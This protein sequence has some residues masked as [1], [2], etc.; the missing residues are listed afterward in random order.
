MADNSRRT[1]FIVV[2]IVSAVLVASI[3]YLLYRPIANVPQPA[4][5]QGAIRAGSPEFERYR[6]K[7]VLDSIEA[8]ES[9]RA[10]GDIVMTLQGTVR[11]FTGRTINGLEVYGAVVDLNGKPV[12]EKT[13]A[14]IPN[15]KAEL[16][17]NETMQARVLLEGISKEAVR[18]NIKM[19][20]VAVR[21]KN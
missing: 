8:F 19:E 14:V 11:N 16:A 21:F 15:Q 10:L 7:I 18:A 1:I 12:K 3:I 9:T 17:P 2:G 6:D 4:Q 20:V 5:L 13:V